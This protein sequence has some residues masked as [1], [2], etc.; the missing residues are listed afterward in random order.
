[1][2]NQSIDSDSFGASECENENEFDSLLG[3]LVK[4]KKFIEASSSSEFDMMFINDAFK[5]ITLDE[6]VVANNIS[7]L[8]LRKT[9]NQVEMP[10]KVKNYVKLL[11]ELLI[12]K[13]DENMADHRILMEWYNRFIE[14]RDCIFVICSKREYANDL[15]SV[16]K[17][18]MDILLK[19]F[20]KIDMEKYAIEVCFR[21]LS[22]NR[23]LGPRGPKSAALVA[24]LHCVFFNHHLSCKLISFSFRYSLNEF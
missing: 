2:D 24:E 22:R 12:M 21:T 1:M 3:F 5:S 17:Y 18:F 16:I 19:K 6:P 20:R 13:I 7:S 11:L 15:V 8:V 10:K 23:K 4:V 9:F 14:F